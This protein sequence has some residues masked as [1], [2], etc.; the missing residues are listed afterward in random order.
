MVL[1]KGPGSPRLK[2]H[3]HPSPILQ[4]CF[5]IRG[6][7]M[8]PTA[9]GC[10][11]CKPPNCGSHRLLWVL[12]LMSSCF[13]LD[14]GAADDVRLGLPD[15]VTGVLLN[16]GS[17]I[18]AVVAPPDH[19]TVI[20]VAVDPQP[21]VTSAYRSRPQTHILTAAVSDRMGI[22]PFTIYNGGPSSSLAEWS[23]TDKSDLANMRRRN[24]R[25]PP[26]TVSSVVITLQMLL[27][28][29]PPGVRVMLVKT[30][31]QG[32]DFIAFRGAGLAVQRAEFVMNEVWSGGAKS[33][34]GVSNSYEDD[35]APHMQR[36]GFAEI[37]KPAHRGT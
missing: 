25:S 29:I 5:H 18:D 27:D 8:L 17:W 34:K 30:D 23:P 22:R 24:L 32:F 2:C 7:S 19:P 3:S 20:T 35:W 26:Y 6:D 28:A 11:A 9:M 1:T 10:T 21:W 13:A 36:I 33:Y 15:N 31:M 4:G 37:H 16:I 12:L 14:A